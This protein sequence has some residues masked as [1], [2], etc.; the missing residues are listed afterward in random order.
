MELGPSSGRPLSVAAFIPFC[1]PLVGQP[2]LPGYVARVD[3]F[4]LRPDFIKEVLPRGLAARYGGTSRDF[5]VANFLPN[6]MAIF[7]PNWVVREATIGRSPLRF[8]G[9]EFR[10]SKWVEASE[11]ERGH[12]QHK[13]WIRLHHWPILC[14]TEKD[15]TAAISGFGELWEVDP[16]SERGD[17]VSFLR[18]R[19]RY[20]GVH[21]IPEWLNLMVDDRCFRIPIEVES[22]EE[23]NP[24]LLGEELDT[25]LGLLSAE[26]QET[27][28]RQ[29]GST[30]VPALGNQGESRLPRSRGAFGVRR[31]DV[32]PGRMRYVWRPV[33][34]GVSISNSNPT[35][36]QPP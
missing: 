22:W 9:A 17:D 20:Q 32:E 18:A 28:L 5:K 30:S 33:T 14:W 10:I 2:S 25:H 1:P 8:E 4:N 29:L 21:H 31:G 3:T 24:I 34:G 7:F 12:L 27:F 26:D 36:H 35:V 23:A 13:A 16:L 11:I 6:A 19:I 15:V